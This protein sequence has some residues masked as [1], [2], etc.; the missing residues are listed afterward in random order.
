M[1]YVEKII[2]DI[3]QT[4]SDIIFA[5]ASVWKTTSYKESLKSTQSFVC[6]RFN[7]FLRFCHEVFQNTEKPQ[8]RQ[9]CRSC[10][11]VCFLR[12]AALW[13]FRCFLTLAANRQPMNQRLPGI[14]DSSFVVIVQQMNVSTAMQGIA[15]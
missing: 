1:S 2:S 14:Y 7:V 15:R 9:N 12:D 8:P 5:V 10:G 11:F 6:Q 13:G 4:T 3:I